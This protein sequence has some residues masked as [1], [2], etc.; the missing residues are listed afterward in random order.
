MKKRSYNALK[1]ELETTERFN[2][3]AA[4]VANKYATTDLEYARKHICEDYGITSTCYYKLLEYAVV[5]CLVDD[6]TVVNI[7]G[8]SA[9]NQAL[10]Y[11]GSGGTSVAKYNRL[12][13]ARCKKIASKMPLSLVCE[14]AKSFASGAKGT[15][16]Y[17]LA[18]DNEIS[19]RVIDYVLEMAILEDVVLEEEKVKIAK[20]LIKTAKKE[21]KKETERYVRNLGVKI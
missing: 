14:L 9:N 13:D 16:K 10:Y 18:C 2:D 15:S 17:R 20:R 6:V 1:N 21:D 5:E 19:T 8:K 3:F 12:Y 11:E 4:E 7:M